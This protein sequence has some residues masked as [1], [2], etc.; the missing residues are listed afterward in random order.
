M[1]LMFSVFIVAVLLF[2]L[3]LGF[4]LLLVTVADLLLQKLHL[5]SFDFERIRRKLFQKRIVALNLICTFYS[6]VFVFVRCF[7]TPML[8][9]TLDCLFL[10]DCPFRFALTFLSIE[11]SSPLFYS[12]FHV[13]QTL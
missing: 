13:R 2:T 4:M 10:Q 3:A 6:L 11:I 12:N 9:V 8:P 7:V 5:Q 1:F